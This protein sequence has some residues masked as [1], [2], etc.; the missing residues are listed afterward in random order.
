M[1]IYSI[2]TCRSRGACPGHRIFQKE[3]T[4]L[5]LSKIE[6]E[7]EHS[8]SHQNLSG[9]AI[10]VSTLKYDTSMPSLNRDEFI[11]FIKKIE[12]M[13]P[14]KLPVVWVMH[15]NPKLCKEHELFLKNKKVKITADNTIQSRH[16]VAKWTKE[17]LIASKRS[18][19]F[20]PSDYISIDSKDFYKINKN[21]IDINHYPSG[22]HKQT[23]YIFE[24]L[25]QVFE[26]AFKK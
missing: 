26:L 8:L 19:I 10:E 11:D 3:H 9:Y 13:L 17:A 25:R 12:S 24:K 6:E 15:F 2:L 18:T 16:N 5:W 7:I 20:D 1:K 23:M 4:H 22:G 21:Q 14:K